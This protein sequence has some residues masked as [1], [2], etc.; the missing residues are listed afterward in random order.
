MVVQLFLLESAL[1]GLVG[2]GIG[3]AVGSL[4]VWRLHARG[5]HLRPPGA[6][7]E[8]LIVPWVAPS[9]VALSVALAAAGAVLAALYPAWRASKLSP[10]DA[11][12]S[13]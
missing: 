4:L 3:A 5:V 12:R 8:Q 1:I 6:E 13:N 10:V 2:G 7:F 9:F 11:L